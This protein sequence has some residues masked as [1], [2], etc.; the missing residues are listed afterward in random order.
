LRRKAIAP[1][2]IGRNQISEVLVKC[3]ND[4][5]Y[6]ADLIDNPS[7][8]LAEMGIRISEQTR[9]VVAESES[10]FSI[11]RVAGDIVKILLPST[12]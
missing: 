3:M 11:Q 8:A 2:T 10:M 7:D 4:P 9:L 1:P 12:L 6:K 5:D